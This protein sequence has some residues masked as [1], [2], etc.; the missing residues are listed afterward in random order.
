MEFIRIMV[1]QVSLG[2]TLTP[3][4]W[5]S[6]IVKLVLNV[7]VVFVRF[8]R[9]LSLFILFRSQIS[10]TMVISAS[11]THLNSAVLSVKRR[12]IAVPERTIL[13]GIALADVART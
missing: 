12:Q 3:D 1:L 6:G 9:H 8:N 2:L 10:S 5:C 11:A 7:R 4:Q 13:C